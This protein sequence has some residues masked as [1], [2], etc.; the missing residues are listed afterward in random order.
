MYYYPYKPYE[1][2]NRKR[3]NADVFIIMFIY[4]VIVVEQ[5]KVYGG[6]CISRKSK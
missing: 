1:A 2:E 6:T 4:W 3:V 5:L